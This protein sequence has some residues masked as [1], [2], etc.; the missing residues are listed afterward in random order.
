M[1]QAPEQLRLHSIYC[2]LCGGSELQDVI[3]LTDYWYGVPGSFVVQ[4]CRSCRHEFMNPQPVGESLAE[5]YPDAYGPHQAMA[6]ATPPDSSS[7]QHTPWYLRY[8]PLRHV[9]GLKSLFEWLMDDRSQ[10][11]PE[12]SQAETGDRHAIE[13]GCAAGGYLQALD[14]QGWEAQGVELCEQPAAAA[15]QAGFHVHHGTLHTAELPARSFELAAAWMV[16]EHVPQPL[17]TLGQLHRV[18]RPGGELLLSVPN[19][20]CWQRFVFGRSWY[21]WDLPRHLQHFCPATM[22]RLLRDANFSDIEVIHQR[23]L[24]NMMG[25]IGIQIGKLLPDSRI[26][27]WFLRYPDQPQLWVQLLLAPFAIVLSWLH[28]GERLTVRAVAMPPSPFSRLGEEG[29]GEGAAKTSH[30]PEDPR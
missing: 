25:S 12:S 10:P 20:R 16:L 28:Q 5:C 1:T 8:L 2:P 23:T 19:A 6:A 11:L 18:L 22:T 26:G 21:G 24:L 15:R 17:E 14:E 13:L 27:K 30:N 9:P 3:S 29:Q 4:R 7:P